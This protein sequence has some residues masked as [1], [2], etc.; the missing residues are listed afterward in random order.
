MVA[1]DLKEAETLLKNRNRELIVQENN[2]AMLQTKIQDL[3][4]QKETLQKQIDEKVANANIIMS[5][6]RSKLD[7]ERSFIKDERE[8]L[9]LGKK[10]VARQ[11]EI[12]REDKANFTKEKET[13]QN[14]VAAS[15]QAR[16]NVDQFILS[17]KRAYDVLG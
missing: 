3:I 8:K 6:Q 11:I 5:E 17:V 15:K 7:V 13:N 12:L 4:R 14:F 2:L 10:E 16:I 9:E 1:T